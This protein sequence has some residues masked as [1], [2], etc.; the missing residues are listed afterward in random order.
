MDVL[1][2][3]MMRSRSGQRRPVFA[4]QTLR[5]RGAVMAEYGLLIAVV[6]LGVAAAV[7]VFHDELISFFSEAAG[8]VA[9]E[10]A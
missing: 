2:P 9:N 3:H 4:D 8:T 10:G 1:P 6:F 7:A 5:E